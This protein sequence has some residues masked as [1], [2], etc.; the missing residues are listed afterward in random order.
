MLVDRQQLA[1]ALAS[2]GDLRRVR[3]ERDGGASDRP[4]TIEVR[5]GSGGDAVLRSRRWTGD[6]TPEVISAQR[7]RRYLS[8]AVG[9]GDIYVSAAVGGEEASSDGTLVLE[10]DRESLREAESLPL[11][12][13]VAVGGGEGEAPV[14]HSVVDLAEAQ[15]SVNEAARP[16]PAVLPPARSSR[17]TTRWTCSS[18]CGSH[19][20]C[21]S[22]G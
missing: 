5:S 3:F 17:I 12:V 18:I 16:T 13:T 4:R 7:A 8:D 21:T 1:P 11:R 15:E 9:E 6:W 2:L 14:S 22:S 10:I 19:S 20:S